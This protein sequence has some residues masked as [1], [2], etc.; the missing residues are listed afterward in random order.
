MKISRC[1]R[2]IRRLQRLP[3]FQGTFWQTR[4]II[5]ILI[6]VV[7]SGIITFLGLFP[8][9]FVYIEYFEVGL[10]LTK[11]LRLNMSVFHNRFF[12][13]NISQRGAAGN[14]GQMAIIEYLGQIESTIGLQ[15]CRPRNPNPR[16]NGYCLETRFPALSDT[17]FPAL[18]VDPR[19]GITQICIGHR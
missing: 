8:A 10:N 4:P 2:L 18:S 15:L 17:S 7:V 11:I 5:T 3:N 16:V 6:F 12:F 1:H 13:L 14:R 19:V 9:S